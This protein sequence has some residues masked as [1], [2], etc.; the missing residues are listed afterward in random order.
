MEE[1]NED[2][3][4]LETFK[5]LIADLLTPFRWLASQLLKLIGTVLVWSVWLGAVAT[6][7]FRVLAISLGWMILIAFTY[8]LVMC[9]WL[10]IRIWIDYEIITRRV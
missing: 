6:I 3:V 5:A 8:I 1:E 7:V 4:Y 10:V 2:E 9:M